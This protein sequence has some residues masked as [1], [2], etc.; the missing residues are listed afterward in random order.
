MAELPAGISVIAFLC[1]GYLLFAVELVVPGGVLGVLGVVSVLWGCWQA[2]QMSM[3]WGG[4]SLI[5]S[6]IVFA[7]ILKFFLSSKTGKGLLLDNEEKARTWKSNREEWKELLG[8]VGTTVSPLRPAGVMM[9]G[10][11][12]YDVV[13]DSE[14]LD[15]NLSVRVTE[16]EGR[17]IMVE[18][19]GEG[20]PGIEDEPVNEGESEGEPSS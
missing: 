3:V 2:F 14:F 17:R 4:A 12:R 13:S 5:G 20:E 18:P 8:Q 15:A 6:L 9:L 10:G 11:V 7:V 16:V 1:L 19:V